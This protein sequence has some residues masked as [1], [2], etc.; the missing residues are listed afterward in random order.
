M[1]NKDVPNN[2]AK[3][4]YQHLKYQFMQKNYPQGSVGN[5]SHSTLTLTYTPIIKKSLDYI[6]P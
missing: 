6:N 2:I 5:S 4:I 3:I 1:F